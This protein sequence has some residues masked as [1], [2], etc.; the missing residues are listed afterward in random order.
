MNKAT[1]LPLKLTPTDFASWKTQFQTLMLGYDLLGYLDNSF[2]CPPK[3]VNHHNIMV[4]YPDFKMWLCQD[5]LLRHAIHFSAT[6]ALQPS[7]N[8]IKTAAL[9]WK[10]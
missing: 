9:A 8:S 1:Q 7:L 10:N 5:A 2:P 4:E 6:F 3:Y